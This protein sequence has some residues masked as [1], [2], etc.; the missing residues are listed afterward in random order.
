[1]RRPTNR[2][3]PSAGQPGGVAAPLRRRVLAPGLSLSAHQRCVPGRARR[4][5]WRPERETQAGAG[6][7]RRGA[8]PSPPAAPGGGGGEREEEGGGRGRHGRRRHGGGIDRGGAGRKLVQWARGR[9]AGSAARERSARGGQRTAVEWGV[10][11]EE[12]L[13]HP[14]R[15]LCGWR[16]GPSG[17]RRGRRDGARR[18]A[19]GLPSFARAFAAVARAL[20]KKRPAHEQEPAASRFLGVLRLPTAAQR[21]AVLCQSHVGPEFH[22]SH[23]SAARVDPRGF[24]TWKGGTME[25][26]VLRGM[27]LV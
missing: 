24:A 6:V 5:R 4:R 11:S 23:P 7:E 18:R 12:G 17:S 14:V 2:I 27:D 16:I 20:G 15:L 9:A 26:G 3:A 10:A 8:D 21:E 19:N 25:N 13:R 22:W 1:M